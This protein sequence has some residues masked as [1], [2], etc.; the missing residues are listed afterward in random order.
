MEPLADTIRGIPIFSS[1]S[2]EDV[3]KI[4]GKM[5]ECNLAAGETI[6]R[7]GDQGDAFYLNE[8]PRRKQRGIRI[9]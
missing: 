2:R 8:E 7:Q 4:M 6:F 1:L 3:A 9:A 5:E